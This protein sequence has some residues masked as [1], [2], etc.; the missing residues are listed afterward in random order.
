M[1]RPVDHSCFNINDGSDTL[2][3][4]V[5]CLSTQNGETI[6]HYNTYELRSV[7]Q[8][9]FSISHRSITGFEALI[10][11]HDESGQPVPI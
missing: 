7:Y 9:I 11:I 3:P 10:R 8:P 5:R 6:A 2:L 1:D 4:F